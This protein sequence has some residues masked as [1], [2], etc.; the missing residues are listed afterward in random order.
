MRRT[1]GRIA[2]SALER[3]KFLDRLAF[4]RG[5]IRRA[6]VMKRFGVSMQMASADIRRY[7]ETNPTA[8]HYDPRRKLYVATPGAHPVFG[9]S[10]LDEALTLFECDKLVERLTPPTR[11]VDSLV[12]QALFR[13]ATGAASIEV[14]Y[15]SVRSS[16]YGW[17]RISPHTFVHDGQRWHVRAYCHQSREFKDFV[18]GRIRGVRRPGPAG[19]DKADDTDWSRI[20]TVTVHLARGLK[21]DQRLALS[22][23]YGFNAGELRLPIRSA[24]K[25][26]LQAL[27]G[28]DANGGPMQPR[29]TVSRI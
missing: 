18:L 15:A 12:A 7:C 24:N 13:A 8:L 14:R 16:T 4:W 2:W 3:Q 23:D 21:E 29:F 1:K 27:F 10:T 26:Y 22:A 5:T 19:K 11:V 25:V 17:R 6:D 20:E 9:E 28:M